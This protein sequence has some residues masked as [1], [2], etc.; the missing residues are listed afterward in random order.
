MS[1]HA[2]RRTAACGGRGYWRQRADVIVVGTGV[3][4]LAAA[5]AAQSAGSRVVV[6]GKSG[7][8]ATA[9]AQGGIAVVIPDTDDSVQAHVADTVAAGADPSLVDRER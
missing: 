7:E 4:G 8:T 9:Y 5:R 2:G 1:A 3:A 6:V